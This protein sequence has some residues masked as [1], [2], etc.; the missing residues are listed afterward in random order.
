MLR[1]GP[2]AD[3]EAAVVGIRRACPWLP[4]SDSHGLH[5]QRGVHHQRLTD[6]DETADRDEIL[7]RVV[8]Q[9][10]IEIGIDREGVLRGQEE[11]VA[12]G[13]RSCDRRRSDLVVGAALVLDQNRLAPFLAQPL[14]QAR[15][16]TSAA[17]P[18]AKVTTMVIGLA[19]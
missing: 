19:G 8:R 5:G 12:I 1:C 6:A 7:R 15:A 3:T 13:R 14:R 11:R 16:I 17:P 4:R 18:A 2:V 10:A 9:L